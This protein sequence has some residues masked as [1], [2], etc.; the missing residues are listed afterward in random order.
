MA[1]ATNLILNT[2][3]DEA[4]GSTVAYDYSGQRADG[5][6]V[7]ADFVRGK[8]GNCIEFTGPGHCDV[9]KNVIPII[10]NFT[11]LA[12]LKRSAFPDGFSGKRIGFFVRW[13]AINGYSEAWF[14]LNADTWG[15]WAVVKEGLTIRIYLDT[16]LVKTITLPAQPTGFALLQDI[17]STANGYGCIDEV[18]AYKVAFTQAEIAESLSSVAQLAYS[19]DGTDL[20]AWDIFISESNGLLDRPKLKTP[21]S[22]DWE[23]YHG[24]VVDLDSPRVEEREITLNCVMSANGKID[25]VTKLNGFLDV[26]SKPGT[27]R[28]MVDIHPTKPLLYEVY[29]E[30]GVAITK[31][32][33]DDQMVGKFTLK[34][35][36]P[37]PVKRIVRHQRI[38]NDTKKLTI[39]LTTAKAVTIF[40]GDGT[41]SADV[42]GTNVTTTHEYTGDG[43]YYA[44][45]AGVIEEI[46][47][48]T[49]NGI[50]VWNK[51]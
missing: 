7:N 2:P 47:S 28:L 15:Y 6:V 26:F 51:L 32:W 50:V 29:N 19:I 25:F 49:T 14:N 3:F 36:E 24:T 31:R 5:T 11:L 42:Y 10:G 38:S 22:V 37:A 23:D 18:K 45:I 30:N 40:W 48:F 1:D 44:I 17:Y 9:E 16:A 43:I 12:W 20:K 4:A 39:T 35:K 8:Q 27:R 34:L 46:E 21:F 13:E 33:S 41:K